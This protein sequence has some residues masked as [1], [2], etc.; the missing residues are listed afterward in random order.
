MLSVFPELYNYSHIAPFLLRLAVGAFFMASGFKN[1][2]IATINGTRSRAGLTAPK[3]LG[4]LEILCGA[5]LLVGLFVQPV[6]IAVSIILIA[7]M[8]LKPKP[9]FGGVSGQHGLRFVLLAVLSSL[10]VLGPGIFA[11]DLPL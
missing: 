3:T 7:A 11:F 10:I 8:A 1:V 9:E 2:F 4:V 6:A 5:F